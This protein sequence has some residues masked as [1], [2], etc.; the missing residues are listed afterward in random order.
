VPRCYLPAGAT[1]NVR[2]PGATEQARDDSPSDE[3]RLARTSHRVSALRSLVVSFAFVAPLQGVQIPSPP[4]GFSATEADM[5]VDEARVLSAD[6]VARINRLIFDVKSKSGG[7]IV[8]VT[9]PDIAGRDVGDVALRI[10]REWKVGENAAIG[11]RARNAGVVVLV[12]PKETSSD[13]RGHIS[14]Q[15]GQGV[16]GFITDG[17]AGD[18]RREAIPYF[19][20]QDY[21]S[22]LVMVTQRLAQRYGQEFGFSVDSGLIDARYV[23]A[24]SSPQVV[25]GIPPQALLLGFILLLF[26]LSAMARASRAARGSRHSGCRGCLYLM[27][28]DSLSQRGRYRGGWGGGGFGGGSWG[29]GG[30]FGGFGGGGGFSGGGS[31]GSW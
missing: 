16:E 20:R 30:G 12:V 29:G 3:F 14:I 13:G 26:L 23:P 7:E 22:A 18:I 17:T 28:A 5:V 10:G 9:M 2:I 4:R 6:A 31:S 1:A 11:D 27:L 25:R 19:Q 24:T 15:T 8:V 21:S